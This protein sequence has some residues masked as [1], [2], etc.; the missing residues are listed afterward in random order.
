MS[1]SSIT[2]SL[3]R[4]RVTRMNSTISCTATAASLRQSGMAEM[5]KDTRRLKSVSS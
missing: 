1:Q 2:S 3:M 5:L 4:A